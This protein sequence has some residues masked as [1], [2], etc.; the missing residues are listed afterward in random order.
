MICPNLEM[1]MSRKIALSLSALLLV[2]GCQ[3]ASQK[4]VDTNL[5]SS[6][7]EAVEEQTVA[8]E[9]STASIAAAEVATP[10][11]EGISAYVP[12]RKGTVF[13]WK[14]NWANLPERISYKVEGTMKKGD[15]QYVKFGSVSGF[16]T[17]T[18]AF[19]DTRDFSLKGY[20]D[21]DDKAVVT[22][23]PPEQRYK[24]PMAPGDKWISNWKQLEHKSSRVTSGGGI[25]RVMG[26]ETLDLPA[27]KFKTLKVRQPVQKNAPKG[28]THYTWFSPELG[29][30]V[31][32]EIGGGI[33]NW[34]QILEKVEE[35]K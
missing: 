35:P 22:F 21:K 2:A 5:A 3:A 23:K 25:V 32:E 7:K 18:Y 29:I 9:N 16:K 6:E 12:P 33:L 13:T 17:K 34:T 27:G 15:S 14:N 4:G 30:T 24:F 1:G 26:W 8:D 31:K 10:T 19:Y 20:R 28:L 11:V